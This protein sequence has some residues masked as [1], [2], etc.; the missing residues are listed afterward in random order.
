MKKS[1]FWLSLLLIPL[2][3]MIWSCSDSGSSSK[4]SD[5]SEPMTRAEF[6]AEVSDYF[7]WPHPDD[8]NDIWNTPVKKFADIETTDEY[9][10]LVEA[11]YQE[12]IIEADADD[13]F[14]PDE[15]ITYDAAITILAEAFKL[16]EETVTPYVAGAG[17]TTEQQDETF[18]KSDFDA[19]FNELKSDFVAPP[20]AL[21]RQ[22]YVAPRRYVKLYTVTPDATIHYTYCTG[23]D[24]NSN[25][26]EDPTID[27]PV[28]SVAT[29]GHIN[30]SLPMFG[31][32]EENSNQYVTYKAISAKGGIVVSPVQTFTWHLQRPVSA[33]YSSEVI[34]EGSTTSPRVV[35]LY[36]NS[37]SLRPMAWYIEGSDKA[38]VFDALFT[39]AN[40]G[41]PNLATYVAE[42]LLPEGKE[43]NL[44]I[45]HE[46]P[47]H[48]AQGP[49]FI[50]AGYGVFLNQ[51]GWHSESVFSTDQQAAIQNIE[52]GD[53][54]D[55]GN[56][57]LNV[58]ALPGHADGLVI[59]Q[60]KVNGM[61][62]ATDI[63]GCTRAGSADNVNVSGLKVDRLLSFTQQTYAN[64]LKDDGKT[65]MLFT[66]HDESALNDNNLKLY[67]AALQ[68]VIDKGE[69]GCTTTLRGTTGGEVT[70]RSTLIGD[71]WKDGTDWIAL[72]IG[73][74]MGDATEYLTNTPVNAAGQ[75]T[76]IN[77]NT[78]L[79][80]PDADQG[81]MKYSV[82]SNI[83]I[84]GGELVGVDVSWGTN[85]INTFNWGGNEITVPDLLHNK[86]D[87]W[88]YNYTIEVPAE[89]SEITIIPV[90]M[91][92]K[93]QSIT[94]NNLEVEY[95]SRN[96]I[97]VSDGS[98][99]T[100][101]IVAPDG[102]TTSHYT[103]IV[104]TI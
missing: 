67:E 53:I 27:S 33:P 90:S 99:I 5:S 97:A 71:M 26:C 85:P 58:Y 52:E 54:I 48:D 62:F 57:Q 102:E 35:Q 64:Y 70:Q 6:V 39:A 40:Q 3:L 69:D 38:I 13:N 50:E 73:G 46:H 44:I 1:R 47:D 86:F 89:N 17:Y 34:S 36:N 79:T 81:F 76:N 96:T 19:A 93:V 51:R 45:G 74:N 2:C 63:Y 55:L 88:T 75:A 56:I 14:N 80:D 43:L 92:T 94:L 11:A 82:L 100:I 10:K 98:I 68:Q 84:E 95:R 72:L 83:E 4:S 42:N 37:E 78:D 77:Y 32:T 9:G 30:H 7:Q 24:P 25:T 22:G 65:T 18:S 29:K 49:N 59:L 23:N 103:F 66:G 104:Q 15:N 61:I 101:D 20:Y 91:S 28:Y 87:P 21:P 8:Y 12:G 60:D 31:L 16:T 41:N